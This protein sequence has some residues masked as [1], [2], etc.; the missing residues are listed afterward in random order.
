VV[1]KVKVKIYFPGWLAALGTATF[2]WLCPTTSAAGNLYYL[3]REI[4]IGGEGGWDYLSIDSAA[5]RLYVT[6]STKIV[7]IDLEKDSIA[8]EITDTPGVHGF[9]LAR[10]LG[11]G[12]SSNGNEAKVSIIDLKTL[13]TVA[14]VATDKNPD[15]ILY[16]PQRQEVYVFNGRGNS[17]TVFEAKTGKLVANIPL[18]GKPE[19]AT[20]DGRAGFVYCNIEDKNEVVVI[21]TQAHQIA[22]RWPIASGEEPTGMALDAMHHR[23]FVGCSNELMLMMNSTNG[24]IIASVP[25]GKGVDAVAFDPATQLAFSSNGEGTVTIAHEESAE[26]LEPIQTLATERGAR[27]MA[28]DS[29]THKI[30]L[31]SARFEPTPSPGPDGSVQRPKIL[32]SSGKVLIYGPEK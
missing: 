3:L 4:S 22:A 12:F 17:A 32:G 14:K 6:H 27:T 20:A 26:K 9:A 16:E 28:L 11:R 8:G 25:I 5:H 18:P 15:A 21:E 31:A 29:L 30:Y 2:I 7:V 23:L 19:F 1:L 24:K 10:E 13:R